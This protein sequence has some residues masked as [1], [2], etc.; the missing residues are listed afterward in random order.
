MAKMTRERGLQE[1]RERKQLKK[2]MKKQ[3]AA[4]EG[5]NTQEAVPPDEL[6][7]APE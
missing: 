6:D 3:L 5:A 2:E 4:E 7:Q 1:K